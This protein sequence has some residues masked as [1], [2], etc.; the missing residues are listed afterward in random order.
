M[1]MIEPRYLSVNQAASYLNVSTSA[2]R[3]WI[4][5]GTMPGLCRINGSIRCDK[6]KLDNSI[7]IK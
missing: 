4:R 2:I 3:K 1:E 7:S 5:L 6:I